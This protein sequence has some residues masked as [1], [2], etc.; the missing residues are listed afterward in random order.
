MSQST[1]QPIQTNHVP[2]D[3][4]SEVG[5]M[6][7]IIRSALSG[8]RTAIPVKIISVTNAGGL[9]PIGKVSVQPLVSS[10]DGNGKAWEHGIIHNVPYMRIQG[11]TNGIILDPSVGDVGI[12]TVCDRD[13]STVKNTGKVAAPGS[14]RKND[15]SDMVYLM[16]IIGAAPTQY[17]QFNSSGITIHSPVK[18]NITA[19]QI[20]ATAT[21]QVHLTAP[22]VTVDA[23]TVFRVN[24]AAIE[25]NGPITQISGSGTAE[26]AGN[27]TTPGTVTATT[28]VVGGG[29][30]VKSHKHGG[31]TTG[32]GQTGVPV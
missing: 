32:G 6:D 16:T 7:Y 24:S 21:T 20:D 9:S 5:R 22:N 19:P 26:F 28:D 17:V 13:I 1:N 14:N 4:A 12:A 30:S 8:L 29:K 3:A 18:V 10:V 2:A 15:M 25:L 11:G 31:V 23:A 27:I